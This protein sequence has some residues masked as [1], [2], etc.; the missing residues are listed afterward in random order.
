MHTT[1]FFAIALTLACNSV[2]YRNTD[3]QGGSHIG[4]EH[5]GGE[6][7]G[8][9]G[10]G[11]QGGSGQRDM[12]PTLPPAV[13]AACPIAATWDVACLSGAYLGTMHVLNP[14]TGVAC[15]LPVDL[16]EWLTTSF[17]VIGNDV[18]H[19]KYD[20]AVRISLVDGETEYAGVPCDAIMGWK[21]LVVRDEGALTHYES[22]ALANGTAL[23]ATMD[24]WLLSVADD[25]LYGGTLQPSAIEAVTLPD[26]Q[27]LPST[28]IVTSGV[29]FGLS[30]VPGEGWFLLASNAI[31]AFD[32]TGAKLSEAPLQ[33]IASQMSGLNG[34]HCFVNPEPT[35]AACCA[36]NGACSDLT[37]AECDA[38][39]GHSWHGQPTSHGTC[40]GTMCPD[41]TQGACCR[42]EGCEDDVTADLCAADGEHH[43]NQICAMIS[44]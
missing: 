5:A 33:G 11:G 6:N 35:V 32:E 25:V 3:A 17:A 19:C 15:A 38:S 20:F 24:G 14:R 21:G 40:A 36:L 39:D 42:A 29:H 28:S 8:D 30:V 2:S 23:A 16:D 7:G 13:L 31:A 43:P 22:F 9:G 18:I 4:G 27:S 12:A 37:A 34:L 41:E 26:G 44:C 10:D 1:F